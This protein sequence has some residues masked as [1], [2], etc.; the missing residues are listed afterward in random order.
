MRAAEHDEIALEATGLYPGEGGV[1]AGIGFG[2]QQ[3]GLHQLNLATLYLPSPVIT[4][5]SV[6]PNAATPRIPKS[7]ALF[8]RSAEGLVWVL[9]QCSPT[10]LPL[11]VAASHELADVLQWVPSTVVLV[12]LAF[13]RQGEQTSARDIAE[14]LKLPSANI[15]RFCVRLVTLPVS[16]NGSNSS[17]HVEL[18][19]CHALY[20][21]S[22]VLSN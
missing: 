9:D 17:K 18:S 10:A 19:V 14:K 21:L 1:G 6:T 13:V 5:D 8:L 2:F 15:R 12:V 20:W 3:A 7:V 22:S 16:S 11:E 4:P